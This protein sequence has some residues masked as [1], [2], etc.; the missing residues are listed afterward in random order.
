M[1]KREFVLYDLTEHNRIIEEIIKELNAF[2]YYFDIKLILTEALT[3]A[4]KHGNKNDN[5]KPIYLR[6]FY[7]NKN[8]TFE[9][10]DSGSNHKNITIPDEISD[11][12]LLNTFGR[13]L[14]LIKSMADNVE[15]KGNM[16]V[17]Q[18][19]LN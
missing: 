6:Y 9:I 18:K 15:S 1:K 19:Y 3:N 14:F 13:G 11:K 16:L 4:Y 10:E 8:L 7:N 2:E 5:K 12:N 17:I